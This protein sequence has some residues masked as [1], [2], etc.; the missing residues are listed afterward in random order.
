MI[1]VINIRDVKKENFNLFIGRYHSYRP[2]SGMKDGTMLGNPYPMK[3]ESEREECI[4]KFSEYF[5]LPENYEKFLPYLKRIKQR[6]KEHG[7]VY[8]VC[9]CAPKAC[10]GDIIKKAVDSLE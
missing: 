6:E 3:N 7:T 8:L 2:D 10:H 9:F 5:F 4:R 1:K